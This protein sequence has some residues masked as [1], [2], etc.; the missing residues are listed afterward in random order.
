M[1]ATAAWGDG[2]RQIPPEW[3][4][5][6][7]GPL[8]MPGALLYCGLQVMHPSA[9]VRAYPEMVNLVRVQGGHRIQTGDIS[10]IFRGFEFEA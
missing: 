3:N 1:A 9:M 10:F 2:N 5:N 6:K 4:G 7:A 8:A